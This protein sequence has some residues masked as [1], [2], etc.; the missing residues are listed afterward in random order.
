M[1][2]STVRSLRPARCL[3]AALAVAAAAPGCGSNVA[4]LFPPP[5]CPAYLN[6]P[7]R[8]D[9]GAEELEVGDSLRGA[10][11]GSVPRECFDM[12][13]SVDWSAENPDVVSLQPLGLN[14][15]QLSGGDISRAWV[16]GRQSG[17]SLVEAVIRLRDGGTRSVQP[18]PLRVVKHMVP[19]GSVVVAQ[20]T[21]GVTFNAVRGFTELI[22]V[23]IPDAGRVD[24]TVDW[25]KRTNMVGFLFWEGACSATPCPN[26]VVINADFS[27]LTAELEKPRQ[28]SVDGLQA[29]RYTLMA[30]AEGSGPET[31]RHEVRLTPR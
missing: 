11:K 15:P 30:F 27:I 9:F 7:W 8:V 13:A 4:G 20:G 29:G 5:D 24:I 21:A 23:R 26:R 25:E 22:E 10:V 19:R 2:R 3:V 12:I 1:P 14:P 18:A 31:V 6:G 17:V 16:T 28:E